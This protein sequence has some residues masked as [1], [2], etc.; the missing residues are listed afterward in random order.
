MFCRPAHSGNVLAVC[1][2]WRITI[3]ACHGLPS[4]RWRAMGSWPRSSLLPCLH[5]SCQLVNALGNNADKHIF[6]LGP[7]PC[8]PKFCTRGPETL[9]A[10]GLYTSARNRVR[11]KCL[12][13]GPKPCPLK[14]LALG[15]GTLSSTSPYPK[16][17]PQKVFTF[18]PVYPIVFETVSQTHP[19]ASPCVC[20]AV[21]CQAGGPLDSGGVIPTDRGGGLAAMVCL[22][23]NIQKEKHGRAGGAS[24]LGPGSAYHDKQLLAMLRGCDW[25]IR[26]LIFNAW[27]IG[28]QLFFLRLMAPDELLHGRS[29]TV[30]SGRTIELRNAPDYIVTPPPP[31]CPMRQ[32]TL[33]ELFRG[34]G[35][36]NK[37]KFARGGGGKTKVAR[38]GKNKTKVARGGGGQA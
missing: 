20:S 8:P 22:Q 3:A 25:Q 9:P 11:K 36:R 37:T 28:R 12:H 1:P 5:S 35:G 21:F 18:G 4:P 16:P 23:F 31:R 26:H 34:G 32:M 2:R 19:N 27:P 30:H 10:P 33:P 13:L 24:R 14:V 29:P 7:Q 17:C 38:G 6:R 15:P